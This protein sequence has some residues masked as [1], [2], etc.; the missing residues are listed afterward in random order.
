MNRR[1]VKKPRRTA[2]KRTPDAAEKRER[3]LDQIGDPLRVLERYI[4]FAAL[5]DQVDELEPRPSGDRGGRPPYPTEVMIRILTLKHLYNLSDESMEF[6]LLD[7]LSFQRFCGLQGSA[8][9]PDRTTIW[10]FEQRLVRA[11]AGDAIFEAVQRELV[12][13]GYIARCGQIVDA[14]LIQAP[15]QHPSSEE[16]EIL[17]QEATPA[18]WNRHQ[19]RQH[20]PDARWTKKHG[21]SY[22][23]Y[24]L[25]ANVDVRHKLIR[26]CVISDAA[27]HDVRHLPALLD[28]ANTSADVYADRGYAGRNQEQALQAQGY[29]PQ[30][31]RKASPGKKLDA[32]QRKRNRRIARTRARGEHVFAVLAQCYGIGVR[33]IGLARAKLQLMFASAVYNMRRL[34]S[35]R[36]AG[37]PPF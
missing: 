23:G 34:A 14:T 20:D 21:C 11:E 17:Q 35:L 2:V 6:Q 26:G 1:K 31:Q 8:T 7:R 29:R 9:I 27:E 16:R 28:S 15:R 12:R 10:N 33:C 19:R 32:R 5:A 24:K 37:V 3:K 18:H 30:I 25:S 36:E 13:H 22:F 4:D